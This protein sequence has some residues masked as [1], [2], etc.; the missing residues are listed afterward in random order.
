MHP[1]PLSFSRCV[2]LRLLSR[3]RGLWHFV[4]VCFF[5]CAKIIL[6][7]LRWCFPSGRLTPIFRC[8]HSLWVLRSECMAVWRIYN[9]VQNDP[10]ATKRGLS[11]RAWASKT[12]L[13]L[14]HTDCAQYLAKDKETVIVGLM[15]DILFVK[16]CRFV[17]N[18]FFF[19]IRFGI[20]A[21]HNIRKSV[22]AVWK[23]V[24]LHS[25]LV[26]GSHF[27]TKLKWHIRLC[28]HSK[29]GAHQKKNTYNLVIK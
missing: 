22:D 16:K 11:L 14:W 12:D 26:N 9:I 6:Y 8:W 3:N 19:R 23:G 4:C 21:G 24:L 2:S 7:I 5:F 28:L 29:I 1:S 18:V 13:C 10:K 27:M 25:R 15:E 17:E 20:Y